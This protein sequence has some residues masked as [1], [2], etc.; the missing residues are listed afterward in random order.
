MNIS[1]IKENDKLTVLVEGRIDTVTAPTLESE[2]N[3][4]LGSMSNLVIDFEKVEY[5]SSAGLRI[6]LYFTKEMNKRNGMVLRNVCSDVMEVF[7]IT[8]FSDILTIE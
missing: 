1:C 4:N 8:G 5:I 7:E 3:N 6:L 2:I